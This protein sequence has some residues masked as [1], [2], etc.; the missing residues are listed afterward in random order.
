[1]S[2]SLS[3]GLLRQATY[4]TARLGIYQM[5]L[6]RFRQPDGR[7]PGVIVNLLLGVVSGGLG[8][9]FGTPA[10]VALIRMTLDGR[11]PPAERRNYA[12]VFDAL[13]RI[14]R[15]EGVTKLW[16]G[17]IPTATRAMIVNAAQM[18]TYSQAKQ[19]LISSGLMQQGFPLHAISSL[20]A[21]LVT[22]AV[23]LPVDIIKTRYQN[24]KVIQG[25]PEYSGIFV[26]FY[27][28]IDEFKGKIFQVVNKY[29]LEIKRKRHK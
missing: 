4:T 11:L 17:A 16:R 12:N 9:L 1:L 28:F 15:E 22:T 25:K 8:S 23:S 19:A 27:L 3:A 26:S 5:L 2:S 7:P 21:A 24:M 10:E 20:I 6:E 14:V 29:N 13:V 18:P